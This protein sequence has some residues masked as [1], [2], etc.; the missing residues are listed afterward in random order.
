MHK[1]SKVGSTYY[2]EHNGYVMVRVEQHP[3]FP[4]KRWVARHRLRMAEHLGRKLR[5]N[6]LVHHRNERKG[7][8]RLRNLQIETRAQHAVTHHKGKRRSNDTKRK[9][10]EGA[11]RRSTP[12]YRAQLSKRVKAQHRAGN[13][14]RQTWKEE[15]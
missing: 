13:F 9:M 2:D 14:G 7:E 6:E 8:D 4:G 12:A 5:S 10:S 3:L 11:V 1:V 15:K